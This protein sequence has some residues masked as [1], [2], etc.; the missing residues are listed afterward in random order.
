[1]KKL[2]SAVKIILKSFLLSLMIFTIFRLIQFGIHYTEVQKDTSI[3]AIDIFEMFQYGIRYDLMIVSYIMILPF[4]LLVLSDYT[5][6][7]TLEK[8]ALEFVFL[9]FVIAF[10]FSAAD[11]P[12]YNKFYNRLTVEAFSWF[13][14]PET[15]FGMVFQE[16]RYWFMFIPLFFI[17]WFFRKQIVKIFKATPV[18]ISNKKRIL[19]YFAT[20]LLVFFSLRGTLTGAPLRYRDAFSG[21]NVFLNSLKLNPVFTLEKSYEERLKNENKKV[22]L[23]P[24]DEAITQIKTYFNTQA[25][26]NK[27]PIARKITIDSLSENKKNVVLILMESAAAWKMQSHGDTENRM[28]YLDSIYHKGIS[29]SNMYS[30][31]IHT[32]CG[33]FG[34]NYGFPMYYEKHPMTQVESKQYS[35]LPQALKQ[36]G[37]NTTFFIPGGGDFDNMYDFLLRNKYDTVYTKEDYP[38]EKIVNIWGVTDDFLF[39]Y[40]L[41]KINKQS[42]LNKPFLATILTI[43]DHGPFRFSEEFKSDTENIRVKASQFADWSLRKFMKNAKKQDWYA[44]TI[45]VFVADHGE[46]HG[47]NYKIPLTYNHI[48][49]IFYYKDVV[50]KIHDVMAS[51]IDVF[52]T[53]MGL[54]ELDYTNNTYGIDLLSESRKYSLFNHDKEYGVIGK[55]FLL[56]VDREKTFGLYKYRNKDKTNY[57]NQYPEILKEMEMYYKSHIQ[58]YQYILNN[59]L[60]NIK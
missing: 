1:M 10:L 21:K 41:D 59:N 30:N 28:P 9:V 18:V 3:E 56:I 22:S 36:N 38:E 40:A 32:Y 48:P 27:S 17:I 29:F 45:F 34:V 7:K 58:S 55:E 57:M 14:D 23:M 8:I 19:Y 52:P 15:V 20:L 31:G 35:G 49:A 54:L 5:K 13:K 26:N 47:I 12:Y 33:V 51:Q 46:T 16:I 60:Q 44:N 2:P 6:K 11:I 24:D 4:V 43:S 50:P 39:E 42:K 37:Y 53:L 25:S